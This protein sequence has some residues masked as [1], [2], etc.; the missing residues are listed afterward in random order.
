MKDSENPLIRESRVD[1]IQARVTKK[2]KKE[3]A[4]RAKKAGLNN[5]SDYIRLRVLG[6]HINK[7]EV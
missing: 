7:G 3:A 2:E 5:V 4:A 1:I 6:N